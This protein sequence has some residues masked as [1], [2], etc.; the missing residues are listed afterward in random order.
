MLEIGR[1][2][3][4]V[5]LAPPAR[6]VCERWRSGQIGRHGAGLRD[7][8]CTGC[9]AGGVA[10]FPLEGSSDLVQGGTRLRYRRH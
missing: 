7:A 5:S 10:R 3:R 4:L 9:G 8:Q 1:A 6:G 2:S